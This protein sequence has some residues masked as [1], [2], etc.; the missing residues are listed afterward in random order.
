MPKT[1][2]AL[3]LATLAGLAAVVLNR[4]SNADSA[5]EARARSRVYLRLV[6]TYFYA[7]EEIPVVWA[8][9]SALREARVLGHSTELA[10]AHILLALLVETIGLKKLAR[11]LSAAA[12]LNARA[13]RKQRDLGWVKSRLGVQ[14]MSNCEWE[15][16]L[17]NVTHGA[18]HAERSGDLRLREEL[19]VQRAMIELFRGNYEVARDAFV[20]MRGH[21]Y[22]SG[23]QQVICWGY[24]G[25][26]LISSRLGDYDI[27]RKHC[28]RTLEGMYDEYMRAETMWS[29]SVLSL[30][31]S[32]ANDL[33]GA[34]RWVVPAVEMLRTTPQIAYWMQPALGALLETQ[35][36]LRRNQISGD[37]LSMETEMLTL[38]CLVAFAS[39]QPLG[40]PLALLWQGIHARDNGKARK[41]RSAFTRA[42]ELATRYKMPYELAWAH[43]EIARGDS[44]E[45]CSLVTAKRMFDDLACPYE[46]DLASSLESA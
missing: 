2:L 36:T 34:L 33:D 14:R 22:R 25:D 16:G 3:G 38:K 35:Y 15:K 12:L 42:V 4:P 32:R 18:H 28:E 44:S 37:G 23:N 9:F 13:T 8:T 6:D 41:A 19:M 43:M 21:A 40:Q 27:A 1:R 11:K 10:Q 46:I 29:H 39:R 24:Q 20:E 30:I 7:L 5:E 17:V 26:A 45:S 31:C